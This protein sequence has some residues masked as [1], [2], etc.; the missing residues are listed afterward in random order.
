MTLEELQAQAKEMKEQIEALKAEAAAHRKGKAEEKAAKDEAEKK[1]AELAAAQKSAE[2]KL[3]REKG[4][5]D[6]NLKRQAA[7]HEA[8]LA[9]VREDAAKWQKRFETKAIDEAL[10]LA[11]S[12][13]NAHD[14][15]EVAS[16]LRASV[17]LDEHGV[18]F[19]KAGEG[20]AVDDKGNRLAVDA[21]VS[22]FLGDKPHHVKPTGSGTGSHSSDAS[23]AGAA[24]MTRAAF[25]AQP[26][27]EQSKF[28][29]AGGVVTD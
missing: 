11:A 5:V 20:V 4:T 21:Y 7:E 25:D 27:A 12:K 14:P 8:Q 9:K 13:G 19:V 23:K 24:T 26:P 2:D 15:S 29:L 3:L 28:A 17:A 16:L 1:L 18:A 10:M 22:K 6:E